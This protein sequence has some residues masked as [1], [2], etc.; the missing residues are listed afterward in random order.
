MRIGEYQD[1][2]M[3]RG[4]PQGIYLGDG[5]AEVL[6]PL[7]QCPPEI[8]IGDT[9]RVFVYTDSEDRPVATTQRP[10]AKV[11]EFV[12]LQAVTVTD[13]GAFL[14]WGLAKDLFCPPREQLHP[15]REGEWYMVRVYLDETSQRVVC[16][17]RLNRFLQPDGEGLQQGQAVQIMVVGFGRDVIQVIIDGK[18]KGSLFRDEWHERLQLGDVRD[19][20]VKTIRPQDKK[21]AVSLRPVGYEAVLGERERVLRSLELNGGVL[22]ISDKSSPEEIQERFGLSKGAFKKILGALYKEGRIEIEPYAIRL[23][24]KG[25]T[26]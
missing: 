8:Q 5:D 4:A 19:A 18:I 26:R 10:Y 24:S 1:L 7:R 23:V 25:K 6:L 13:T 21:V 22:N 20:F 16:T 12:K 11:G 14:D 2:R 17:S 15:M 3:V 9:L